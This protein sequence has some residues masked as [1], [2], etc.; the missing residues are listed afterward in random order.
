MIPG[1]RYVSNDL[2]K[3]LSMPLCVSCPGERISCP[4]RFQH[5]CQWIE[6]E[7]HHG[8]WQR[9]RKKPDHSARADRLLWV[10]GVYEQLLAAAVCRLSEQDVVVP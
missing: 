1:V 6:R 3:M 5:L 8:L 9:S 10:G 7:H 4:A 2:P